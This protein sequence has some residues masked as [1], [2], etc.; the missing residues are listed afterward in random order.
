MNPNNQEIL[1][2]SLQEN[3]VTHAPY[4]IT[5]AEEAAGLLER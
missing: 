2:A 4:P 5:T 1:H 3:R